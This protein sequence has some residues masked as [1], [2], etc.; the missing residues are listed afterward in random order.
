VLEKDLERKIVNKAKKLGYIA[1]KYS[2]PSNRGVPDRIFISE[3]GKLFFVEFKSKKG[4]LSKLQDKK[5]SELRARK[6]SIFVVDDEEI[7][8]KLLMEYMI[9]VTN[10]N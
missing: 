7:G 3:N 9:D 2:S 1:D 8:M 4:K 10:K 5:I 6:Q